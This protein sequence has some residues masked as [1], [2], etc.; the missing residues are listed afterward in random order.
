[1]K[2]RKGDLMGRY[3]KEKMNLVS[4]TEKR[5]EK[6]DGPSAKDWDE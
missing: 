4:R 3:Y 5:T 2:K 1:M 6:K